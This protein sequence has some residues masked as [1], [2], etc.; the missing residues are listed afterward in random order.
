MPTDAKS[1]RNEL[2]FVAPT[3][4]ASAGRFAELVAASRDVGATR[5]RNQKVARIADYL[6]TLAGTPALLALGV[7][8]LAG[9]MPQG[10]IGLGYAQLNALR[11]VPPATEPSV[12]LDDVD[13]TLTAIKDEA[14]TGSARR[15]I[16][17]MSALLARATADEQD[18]LLRLLVAELRHGALEGVVMDGVAKAFEHGRIEQCNPPVL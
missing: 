12:R 13:R 14:G 18:F 16:E 5:A 3:V 8:Y 17:A 6:R 1:I 7:A 11:S 15:R 9:D 2:R 4:S 10:R